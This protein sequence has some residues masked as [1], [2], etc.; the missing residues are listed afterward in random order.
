VQHW[1][2]RHLRRHV[3]GA[4][5]ARPGRKGRR[6]LAGVRRQRQ[7]AGHHRDGGRP[8]GRAALPATWHRL[9]GLDEHRGEAV[10]K[11]L[12]A[13][14]PLWAPGTAMA[15]HTVTDG[16]LLDEIVRR[17]TGVSVAHH[18]QTLIAEPLDVD[19]WMGLPEQLISRVV[20]GLWEATSPMEPTE[21]EAVPSSYAALRQQFL[22]AEPHELGSRHPS[23][24]G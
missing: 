14:P 17:A 3:G 18:V 9:Q 23:Q 4:L 5:T 22:R 15:Y 6:L 16:T 1:H 13:A 2:Y 11:A 24:R 12:A 20:P 7:G 19:M 21:E 8:H 10:T